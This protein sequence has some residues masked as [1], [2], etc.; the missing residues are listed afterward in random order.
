MKAV[1][2]HGSIWPLAPLRK[3]KK[4]KDVKEALQFGNHKG[5]EQ[6]QD[7]LMKLE[8]ENVDQGFCTPASRQQNCFHAR[9]L[10]SPFECPTPKTIIRYL[11]CNLDTRHQIQQSKS[12]VNCQRQM[13]ASKCLSTKKVTAASHEI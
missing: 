12:P 8:K 10:P 2:S 1:L 13:Q 9:Q 4:I 5:A 11:M 6:Q 3:D 7:L